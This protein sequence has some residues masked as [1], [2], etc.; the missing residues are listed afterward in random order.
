MGVRFTTGKTGTDNKVAITN[1]PPMTRII[2]EARR[3]AA[4][5]V[6][7]SGDRPQLGFGRYTVVEDGADPSSGVR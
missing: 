6:F 1:S 3:D 7:S 4:Q 5:S 2:N